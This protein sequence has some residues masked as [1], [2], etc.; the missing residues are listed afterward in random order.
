MGEP[1]IGLGRLLALDDDP[2]ERR[3]ERGLVQPVAHEGEA[4][5]GLF[6]LRLGNAH[7]G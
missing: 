5:L 3:D 4:G 7:L 2:V 1:V 6:R